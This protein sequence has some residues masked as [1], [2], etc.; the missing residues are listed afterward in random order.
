MNAKKE[1]E[2]LVLGLERLLRKESKIV[3]E[4]RALAEMLEGV[5]AG[6]LLDWVVIEEEAHHTLLIN[7][8]HSLKRMALK[9]SEN[10]ADGVEMERD[11]VLCWLQRLRT[12]ERAVVAACR[13]LKSQAC[14]ENGDLVDAFLDA[15]MMDSEKHQRFLSAVEKTVENLIMSRP[16]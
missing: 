1:R 2:L 14:W 12:E 13:T 3:E 6:L 9:R 8:I 10:V 15:L 16:Q 7:I 11:T 5:P 4:Y